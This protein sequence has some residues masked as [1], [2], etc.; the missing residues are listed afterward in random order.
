MKIFLDTLNTST[1]SEF[2]NLGILY[3]VTTNPTL[4]KRFGMSSDIDMINKIRKVM[5]HGEIHVEAFG[6]TSDEIINNAK[7]IYEKSRDSNLV[8]K[9]PFST[10]GVSA[11]KK[12]KDMNLKTNLHLIFSKNQALL[13]SCVGST[14]ICPL[15]GRLDDIGHDAFENL[16]PIIDTFKRS[17]SD[18]MV[19][20]S[21]VRHAQHVIR[22]FEVG[23]DA[24]TIPENVLRSMFNHPLTDS[25]Y[26]KFH[27]DL[28]AMERINMSDVRSDLIVD[29]SMSLRNCL[30]FLVETKGSCLA[31]IDENLSLSGVFTLGDLKRC[32]SSSGIVDLESSVSNFMNRSP[33]V[34]ESCETY[35]EVNSVVIAQDIT[36]IIVVDGN[37]VLGV[38]S[39]KRI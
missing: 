14:Y 21:S 31:I 19:M 32:L 5:P 18:T 8:F 27:E 12:L 34:V 7:R 28:R 10:E 26:R 6:K 24:V 16:S 13:S 23:A 36:D 22:A 4:A 39:C 30:K 15:V 1:I 11:T 35:S 3:G 29:E 33:I 2:Y 25:G 20:V 17:E 37:S 9:I 38:L